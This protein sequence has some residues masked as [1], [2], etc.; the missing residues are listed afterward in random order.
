MPRHLPPSPAFP[1][2]R[3]RRLRQHPWSRA[4]VGEHR[5]GPSDLIQPFF[6]VD[7]EHRHDAVSSMP[8]IERLSIDLLLREAE[9]AARLG[10]PAVALFPLTPPQRKTADGREAWNEQNLICRAVRALKRELPQLG[11]VCDVALDP[12]TSHGQD[13]L[14]HEGKILN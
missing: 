8:G 5:V 3:L 13:G 14:V 6:I 11:V 2:T 12:Y 4:L 7:G 1:A 9:R 10:L